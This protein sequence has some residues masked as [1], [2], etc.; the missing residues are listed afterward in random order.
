MG[1][2]LFLSFGAVALFSFISVSAWAGTRYEERKA[3]YRG[4]TL[5]K[6]AELGANAVVEYLREEERLEE[7]RRMEARERAR[8]GM[9]LS[10]WIVLVVGAALGIALVALVPD[11]PV[12]LLALMPAGVGIVLLLVSR[13]GGVRQ[14]N[15]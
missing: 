1:M 2:W 9:W 8:E 11:R 4:E 12:F 7:R 3:F 13:N 6:L 15:P 14:T 10:G 5:K